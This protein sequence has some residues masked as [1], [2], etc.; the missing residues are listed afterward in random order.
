MKLII[1]THNIDKEKELR[2]VLDDC[3]V[4]VISLEQFPE[5]GDIEETGSTL[6]ENAKLKADTV[7]RITNLPCLGDDTGLE[8]D[9]LGGAPGV[10]SARYAGD[11]VSY[12]DNLMK[13]LSELRST[14]SEKRTARFRTIIF[15]TDGERELYTQGEIQ[16]I[17]TK[18]PRGS[19]GFGYDPV[20]YIP[21][22]K[23][24]MAE[25]TSAEKNKLSH[26]GQAMGKFRKLLLDIIQ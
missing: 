2:S 6:Y 26:R 13:L 3:P 12:E 18:S 5:I 23:K 16:G 20:F 10:Y 14:P 7:N 1:A 25:L 11:K 15:Y 19:N 4:E 24:T 9:A 21:E 22:L 17:I 8:V